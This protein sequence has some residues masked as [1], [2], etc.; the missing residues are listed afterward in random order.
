MTLSIDLN[1]DMG[2]SFGAWK[3]GLDNEILP[4]VTSANIA[5]GYHAGDPAVMRQTVAAAIKHGVA[6]GAHPGLPDLV[7]FGRRT[8]DISPENA[9]DM[10]VVQIG[11]LAA[12]AASQGGR[13]HHVKAHGALYNMAAKNRPLALAIA[14]AV[15]DVNASLVLYALAASELVQAGNDVGL[16]VAQEVFA[17]RTYQQDGSLTSR[18]QPDAMIEDP[19][20]SIQQVLRMVLDG[21]VVTQ[22]SHEIPV[23]A[24]TLCIHGDQPGA[25]MFAQ[26]IRKALQEK[27]IVVRAMGG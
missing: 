19:Q 27:G 22:Q 9:Y 6:L 14:Q 21:R 7:G 8:M 2:E 5:C 1:C 17:D 23:Q 15:Y 20:Q 16:T 11:A 24:D 18:K 3:M 25:A 26:A 10:V 12:V 13:L 4:Y